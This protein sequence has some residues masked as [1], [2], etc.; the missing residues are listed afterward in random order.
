[1]YQL[2]GNTLQPVLLFYPE[3]YRSFLVRLYNFDGSKVIPKSS[4]VISYQGKVSTDGQPY[5]EITSAKSFPSYE[6]ADAYVSN[7]KSGNYR[8]VSSDPFASPVPLEALEH[9]K[10]VY[11]S[12]G[13]KIMPNG[14]LISEVKIFEYVSD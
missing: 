14:G 3:Y 5:K 13:S 9:Y 8:I 11:S 12:K 4:I 6:E 2:N 7:Q 1:Y 10:M